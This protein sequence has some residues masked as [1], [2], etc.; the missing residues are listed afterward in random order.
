MDSRAS[1]MH[2]SSRQLSSSIITQ[3]QV[4]LAEPSISMPN[5]KST[6]HRVPVYVQV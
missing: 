6:E 5:I 1:T 2:P 3:D 4:F